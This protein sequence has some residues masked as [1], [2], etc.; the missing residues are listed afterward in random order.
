MG[1][2]IKINF[3]SLSFSFF[4]FLFSVSPQSGYKVVKKCFPLSADYPLV[5]MDSQ[6]PSL[7][8]INGPL[9][10]F[11]CSTKLCFPS[12]TRLR[13]TTLSWPRVRFLDFNH[14]VM[15]LSI[16]TTVTYVIFGVENGAKVNPLVYLRRYKKRQ[17]FRKKNKRVREFHFFFKIQ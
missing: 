13:S 3:F 5:A 12:D 14:L 1:K 7:P 2:G 15:F 8:V 17:R 6:R 4:F 10:H 11:L 9:A 16:T